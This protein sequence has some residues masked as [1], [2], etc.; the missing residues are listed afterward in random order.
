MKLRF[1]LSEVMVLIEC[2]ECTAIQ[3]KTLGKH[4]GGLVNTKFFWI[5]GSSKNFLISW[6]IYSSIFIPVYKILVSRSFVEIR[7]PL[8]QIPEVKWGVTIHPIIFHILPCFYY[9]YIGFSVALISN[10]I[11]SEKASQAQHL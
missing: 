7:T 6:L 8:Q 2:K 10:C 3:E 5:N 4:A 11:M 9:F 1:H